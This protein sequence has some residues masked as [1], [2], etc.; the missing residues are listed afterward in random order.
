MRVPLE[1]VTTEYFSGGRAG[2][3]AC[4]R[5]LGVA[6]A[7]GC[8]VAGG[9]RLGS[10]RVVGFELACGPQPPNLATRTTGGFRPGYVTGPRPARSAGAPVQFSA[11]V[12]APAHLVPFGPFLLCARIGRTDGASAAELRPRVVRCPRVARHVGGRTLHRVSGQEKKTTRAK[13]T[14]QDARSDR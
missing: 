1:P 6:R 4:E 7:T 13:L 5:P 10:R 9:A 14:E 2:E 11:C 8:A 12:R 3:A